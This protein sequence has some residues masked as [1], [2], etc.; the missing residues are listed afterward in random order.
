ME[1]NKRNRNIRYAIFRDSNLK[2]WS[3]DFVLQSNIVLYFCDRFSKLK[4]FFH[5]FGPIIF[6]FLA[7]FSKRNVALFWEWLKYVCP[8]V[9][10]LSQ[11]P[12]SVF[13]EISHEVKWCKSRKSDEAEILNKILDDLLG[14]KMGYFGPQ[15]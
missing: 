13:S 10:L 11:E 14:A 6:S 2:K 1:C 4:R 3:E 15:N 8:S 7:N 9:T 5:V 12:P